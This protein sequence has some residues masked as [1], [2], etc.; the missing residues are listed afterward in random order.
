MFDNLRMGLRY[1]WKNGLHADTEGF[2]AGS[3]V[4]FIVAGMI[5]LLVGYILIPVV[6]NQEYIASKNA[7]TIAIP[8]ASGLLP[9]GPLMFILS[10]VV[11]SVVLVLVVLKEA[12]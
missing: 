11:I 4:G 2:S 3:I 12:E 9:L 5:A 6:A 7:S 8:G 1:G 10:A